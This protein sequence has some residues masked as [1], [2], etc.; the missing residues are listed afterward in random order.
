MIKDNFKLLTFNVRG[1]NNSQKRGD[2]LMWINNLKHDYSLIQETKLHYTPY[3]SPRF[4]NKYFF[5]ND[6]TSARGVGLI[7]NKDFPQSDIYNINSQL[8]YLVT[9]NF[10]IINFYGSPIYHEK[11]LNLKDLDKLLEN[12]TKQYDRPFIL[13]GDF[14]L[15][16]NKKDR[17]SMQNL[18]KAD[19]FLATILD[20]HK[21]FDAWPLMKSSPGF[22][23]YSRDGNTYSRIDFI[24]ISSSII[25]NLKEIELISSPFSD[26]Y[27][28]SATF[29]SNKRH[30]SQG[31]GYWKLNSTLLN[32][33]VFNN[34][35]NEYAPAFYNDKDWFFFKNKIKET[36]ILIS[37]EINKI[38]NQEEIKFKTMISREQDIT[39][40]HQLQVQINEIDKIKIRGYRTR[41]RDKC[42]LENERSNAFFLK[43]EKEQ[44]TKIQI[45]ELISDKGYIVKDKNDILDEVHKFYS[46]LW[47]C[48]ENNQEDLSIYSHMV[49][50]PEDFNQVISSKITSEELN[51][52]IQLMPTNK[53]PGPDGIG[54]ELYQSNSAVRNTLLKLFNNWLENGYVPDKAKRSI[55]ILLPKKGDIRSLKNW[56]PITLNN[57]DFK[58]FCKILANRIY[59]LNLLSKNQYCKPKS[60]THNA[61]RLFMDALHLCKKSFKSTSFVL[62]DQE[63]AF[64]RVSR[65]HLR[66]CLIKLGFNLFNVYL[67]LSLVLNAIV[68]V[69]VNGFFTD[70]ITMTAGVFQGNPL[71]PW[72]YNASIEPLISSIQCKLKGIYFSSDNPNLKLNIIVYADDMVIFC[73]NN[74]DFT[75]LDDLLK[76]FET[77]SNAKINTLKSVLISS[78][79]PPHVDGPLQGIPLQPKDTFFRYLGVM[80]NGFGE[81]S[82]HWKITLEKVKNKLNHWSHRSISLFGKITVINVLAASQMIYGIINLPVPDQVIIQYNKL[83]RNFLFKN[84]KDIALFK[85]MYS[86]DSG[87]MALT[88]INEIKRKQ[89]NKILK[90]Y[91][92]ST[93]VWTCIV[94]QLILSSLP[95]VGFNA[96]LKFKNSMAHHYPP[97][98]S[99]VLLNKQE[100]VIQEVLTPLDIF[101]PP[102]LFSNNILILPRDIK[103]KPLILES[104]PPPLLDVKWSNRPFNRLFPKH[105]STLYKFLRKALMFSDRMHITPLPPCYLCKSNLDTHTHIIT[106]TWAKAKWTSI[107]IIFNLKTLTMKEAF[108]IAWSDK[109]DTTATERRIGS[110]FAAF[111]H[112]V[113]RYR[114]SLAH[115]TDLEW[116]TILNFETE[117]AKKF[118]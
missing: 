41:L 112:S 6:I 86:K 3:F 48:K 84:G 10:I 13:A 17:S 8:M 55:I 14:N 62:L 82:E 34:F 28:L 26:H 79:Q 87:G 54:Y 2:T 69:L 31:P 94:N 51:K 35:L 115:E 73:A 65:N 75:I 105:S 83:I 101:L 61:I 104:L 7:T 37:S 50:K 9:E 32:N 108:K 15:I 29:D 88:N 16:L 90:L 103:P 53:S 64:D 30:H 57:C 95:E 98:W 114:C 91:L 33:N 111:W 24:F 56:R 20:K 40:K 44:K 21:L 63:K 99:E 96:L 23:R 117:V 68:K 77:I 74:Q 72:L 110:T 27:A 97:F 93:N 42:I 102:L 46:K 92:S 45:D 89:R 36:A 47:S 78:D 85:L 109:R 1:I 113:W 100:N 80:I 71:A 60:S 81:S 19:N 116:L 18:S 66:Q 22:T 118:F 49:T 5:S 39:L 107:S 58:I 4:K 70:D 38:N 11:F 106:C 52:I 76:L 67:I 12:L 43:S 59:S 25:N